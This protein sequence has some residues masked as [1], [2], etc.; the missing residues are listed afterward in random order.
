MTQ[1]EAAP[2]ALAYRIVT[3]G[4]C[5]NVFMVHAGRPSCP[6]CG[7]GPGIVL[8]EGEINLE[9]TDLAEGRPLQ[10][11]PPPEAPAEGQREEEGTSEGSETEQQRI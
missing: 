2:A 4:T 9:S 1:P 6:V 11:E 3:C 5:D 8:Q 7:G 10:A